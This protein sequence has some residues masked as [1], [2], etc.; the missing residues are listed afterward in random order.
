M[1]RPGLLALIVLLVASLAANLVVAGFVLQRALDARGGAERLSER[2]A[3][4]VVGHLPDAVRDPLL[5]AIVSQKPELE[6]AAKDIRRSRREV[7]AAMR[8]EPLDAARLR[9]ALAQTRDRSQALLS[10]I[11]DQIVAAMP[12]IP[13][14]DRATIKANGASAAD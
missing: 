12:A 11:D 4:A 6:R 13:A 9:A 1:R 14:G 7:R 10:I 5:R 3:Y 2:A 8:A